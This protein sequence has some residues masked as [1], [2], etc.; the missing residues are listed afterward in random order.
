MK[1]SIHLFLTDVLPEKKRFLNKFVKNKLFDHH[2]AKDIFAN[3]KK[4]NIEGIEILLPDFV[5]IHDVSEVKKVTEAH[6]IKVYSVHQSLRFFTRTKMSEIRDLME[7]AKIL[8]AQVVVLHMN[9]A[10][11]QIFDDSYIDEIHRLQKQY[12]IKIGFENREK[13]FGSVLNGYGWHEK[14]FA[15]FIRKKD[16]F[17]TYDVC[18]M[19]QTGGDIIRFFED[20]KDRIINIHL[21]DYKKHFLNSSLRPIRF[22]HLPLG[23]GELPI[24][25]LINVLKREKYDGLVTLETNTDLNELIK[26]A[27]MI[28]NTS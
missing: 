7:A 25:K 5:T 6:G 4:H 21:S 13:Y 22:K 19:G 3:L 14:K 11:L 28:K 17:I 1:L 12:G 20:N 9:S 8:S 2:G 10:G 27:D 18:H 26:S 23:R 15:D 16:L 24:A